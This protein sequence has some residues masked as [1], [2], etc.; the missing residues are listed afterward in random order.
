MTA[1]TD[2]RGI[3]TVKYTIT[4][5]DIETCN[6]L[7]PGPGCGA[8]SPGKCTSGSCGTLCVVSPPEN[9]FCQIAISA[10]SGGTLSTNAVSVEYGR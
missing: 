9:Q 10:I 7:P 2:S 6:C 4:D 3:A 5:T 8:T 1:T